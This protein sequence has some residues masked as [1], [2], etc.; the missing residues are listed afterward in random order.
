MYQ[1]MMAGRVA[2]MLRIRLSRDYHCVPEISA[3]KYALNIRFTVTGDT[4][5]PNGADTEVE[6][7]L[8]FCNL[9]LR[10]QFVSCTA[11][12]ESKRNG[13]QPI[14][15]GRFVSERC[16]LIDLGAWATES[17]RIP[18]AENKDLPD[19]GSQENDA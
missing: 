7:E 19:T 3:N 17:Y 6:F 14:L 2:Q 16:K 11:V 5:R 10:M 12:R 18:V 15:I 9:S 13:I 4:Q 1:Q 8:T